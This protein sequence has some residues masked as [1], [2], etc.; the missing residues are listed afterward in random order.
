MRK[1]IYITLNPDEYAKLV[2]LAKNDNLKLATKAAQ[3]IRFYLRT[4]KK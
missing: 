1:R 2:K 3:I 4:K